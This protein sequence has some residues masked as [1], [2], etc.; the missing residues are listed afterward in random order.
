MWHAIATTKGDKNISIWYRKDGNQAW[1]G[2]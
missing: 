1:R 2:M